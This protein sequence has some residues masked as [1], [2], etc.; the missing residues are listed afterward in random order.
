MKTCVFII[1]TNCTGKSTLVREIIQRRGGIIRQDK[2]LTEVAGGLCFAGKYGDCKY[3]GVDGWGETRP[4]AEVVGR[5]LEH[6][7]AIICEGSKL[8]STGPHLTDA[9]FRADNRIV[10]MLHADAKTLAKRLQERSGSA[11]NDT[12]LKDQ[13]GCARALKRWQQYGV[14][15]MHIDTSVHSPQECAG[16]ILK[17]IES[18]GK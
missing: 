4:L 1:G 13:K 6:H 14:S 9:L 2:W 18:Y 8:H 15:I 10:C 3:G 17:K 12:I 11:L 5:A 7:D 16:M